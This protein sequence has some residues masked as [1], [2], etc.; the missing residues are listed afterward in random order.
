MEK[1][2]RELK[3]RVDVMLDDGGF[4]MKNIIA[5]ACSS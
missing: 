5:P 4:G 2:G 1:H 3:N